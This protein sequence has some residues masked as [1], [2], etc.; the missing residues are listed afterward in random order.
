[1]TAEH[2]E[3]VHAQILRAATDEHVAVIAYCFMPDHVHLLAE[4]QRDDAD[5]RRFITRAKQFSGFYYKKTFA[6][7]LWQRYGYERTL[8]DED[9]TLSV[10]RYIVEN[11]VRAGLGK[12]VS[13][14]PFIGS[15]VY[16]VDEILEAIQLEDGWRRSG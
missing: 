10:A 16:T 1:M 8:R 4:G 9:A 15:T 13:D 5:C 14:Y 7:S 2:V 12:R 11:P 3:L 6:E